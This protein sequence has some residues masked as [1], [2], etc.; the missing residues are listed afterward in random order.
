[1]KR[2]MIHIFSLLCVMF[3]A[4]AISGCGDPA[5]Y[6]Y[7]PA[8]MVEAYLIVGEPISH[9][10]LMKSTNL[11]DSLN[12]EKSLVRDADVRI[13]CEGREFKL[14]IDPKGEDGYYAIDKSYLVEPGK[15][16]NLKIVMPGGKIVTGKTIT[17]R[18]FSWAKKAP[19][20]IPYPKDTI[21]L[22]PEDSLEIS[23]TGE[24]QMPFYMICVKALD[25][26][27]YGKYL[28]PPTQEKN[29]RIHKPWAE[30]RHF[31]EL[32]SYS[33]VASTKVPIVWNVFRWYGLHEVNVYAPDYNYL[34]WFLQVLSSAQIDPL[35]SSVQGAIGVFG[36]ASVVRDTAFLQKNQP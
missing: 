22:P 13:S 35:L 15:E 36:S 19:R 6:D 26:T 28:V 11:K 23:W 34:R 16:Y 30:D 33:F 5:P 24:A 29:R 1:M 25:T 27:G 21:N 12:Y 14:A 20:V 4:F 10:I 32:A 8:Y 17:P 2:Y 18:V 7:E 31:R 9:V 3:I